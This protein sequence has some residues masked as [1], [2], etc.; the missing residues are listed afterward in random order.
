MAGKPGDLDAHPR[1]G[2]AGSSVEEDDQGTRWPYAFRF[3]SAVAEF[4]QAIRGHGQFR[5]V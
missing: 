1:A 4:E 3:P 5:A 2:L